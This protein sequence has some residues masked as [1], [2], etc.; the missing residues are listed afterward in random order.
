M[1]KFTGWIAAGSLAIAATA[2]IAQE[3]REPVPG[4]EPALPRDPAPSLRDPAPPAG[5]EVARPAAGAQF[6]RGDQEIA[7][8][9]LAFC[10]N[11][12]E[13]AKLGSQKAESDEV[14]Q[15]AAKMVKEHSEE[16]AKLE[17]LA[18]PLAAPQGDR[19]RPAP[20]SDV[21]VRL[22]GA[23]GA[24]ATRPGADVT[25]RAGQSGPLN[26]V[27]INQEMAEQCAST[28]KQELGK[29]EGAEF[30]KCFIGMTLGSH[31]QHVIA[32][33][34]FKTHVS[35]QLRGEIEDCLKTATAHLSEA[36]EIMAKLEGESPRLTRKPDAIPTEPRPRRPE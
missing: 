19:D 1:R 30:D 23:P 27:A 25:I 3:R 12:L 5:R 34:V 13:L 6:T 9:K 11:A 10:R 18:G 20:G 36:K 31:Q 14:K 32:D 8:V 4:R 2:A 24:P 28:T 29:K 35:P 17:K 15:F 16:C 21:E 7:A 26:W 22:P 33:Q